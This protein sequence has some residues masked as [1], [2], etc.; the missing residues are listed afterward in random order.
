LAPAE[1]RAW[2]GML[3]VGGDIVR[4]LDDELQRRDG[5]SLKAFDVLITLHNAPDQRLRMSELAERVVL[6][7]SGLTHLVERVQRAGL[8]AR[9][10]DPDDGRVAYAVLTDAGDRRLFEARAT[11]N[12]VIRA[13]F[14]GRLTKQQLGEVAAAWAAVQDRE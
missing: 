7:P 10:S 11:H 3:R 9:D 5:I 12:E 1:F 4:T 13:Q 2:D 14:V 6:S 8:V